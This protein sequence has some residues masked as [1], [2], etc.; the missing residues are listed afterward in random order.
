MNRVVIYLLII[1]TITSCSDIE[2]Y[3]Y[4]KGK[5]CLRYKLSEKKEVRTIHFSALN[6]IDCRIKADV[7]YVRLDQASDSPYC[8]LEAC[9]EILD[10]ISVTTDASG[11]LILDYSKCVQD[12][13]L[14]VVSVT[15]GGHSLEEVYFLGRRFYSTDTIISNSGSLTLKLKYRRSHFDVTCN[16]PLLHLE[17][18]LYGEKFIVSGY[19]D[20][21]Y[22][23]LHSNNR[24][25]GFDFRLLT[26]RSLHCEI[27]NGDDNAWLLDNFYAGAPDYIYYTMLG[28]YPFLYRGSPQIIRNDGS[29][30]CETFKAE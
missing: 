1:F 21:V 17:N 15:I 9:P 3:S 29:E 30:K 24:N 19:C 7:K 2:D 12:H 5:F 28:C 13:R 14:P 27:S 20:S 10:R 23:K 26:Y 18:A 11:R 6:I 16:V 4:D 25:S 22:S 8:R